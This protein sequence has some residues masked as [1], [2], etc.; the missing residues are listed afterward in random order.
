MQKPDDSSHLTLHPVSLL[1]K[2]NIIFFISPQNYLCPEL[3]SDYFRF[4]SKIFDVRYYVLIE[5][6]QQGN[7]GYGLVSFASFSKC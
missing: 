5:P 1:Q 6:K 3:S 7:S 2:H 4:Y